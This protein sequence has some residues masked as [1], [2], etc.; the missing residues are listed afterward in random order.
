MNPSNMMQNPFVG[1]KEYFFVDYHDMIACVKVPILKALREMVDEDD[2]ILDISKISDM[3]DKNLLRF[4]VLSRFKNP[5]IELIRSEH[6]VEEDDETG[7]YVASDVPMDLTVD[8]CNVLY[9]QILES[10]ELIYEQA[11]EGRIYS[12]IKLLI[13]QSFTAHVYFYSEEYDIRIHASIDHLMKGEEDSYSYVYGDLFDAIPKLPDK[14]TF[15]FLSDA[16]D[17]TNIL[18]MDESVYQYTEINLA[19][20]GYNYFIN[21]LTNQLEL[22]LLTEN[23][24]FEEMI[25][26]FG[27]ISPYVFDDTYY[28]SND[29]ANMVVDIMGQLLDD[30]IEENDS[31]KI[32][33]ILQA[34]EET[35]NKLKAVK[36]LGY[37]PSTVVVMEDTVIHP[38]LLP[39]ED[40][41]K[42][43]PD[44]RY[45]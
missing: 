35:S 22:R 20:H 26:K 4:S 41:D 19:T 10:D 43:T 37:D 25:V 39:D 9:E 45:I 14:P 5:I 31:E 11:V 13:E 3:D 18:S 44:E 24:D 38:S 34:M 7:E 42:P 28:T 21:G 23:F 6:W 8:Y 40:A 17:A 36:E 33:T 1:R 27:M 16:D 12:V 30:A 29:Y 15:Y 2:E 32:S